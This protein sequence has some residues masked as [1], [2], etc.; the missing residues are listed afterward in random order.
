MAED[1]G[2]KVTKPGK[3]TSSTDPDDLV[4]SSE[5]EVRSIIPD[6]TGSSTLTT[7]TDGSWAD[8]EITHDLGY[9]PMVK[10]FTTTDQRSRY[11]ELPG[12]FRSYSADGECINDGGVP[13]Y[14]EEF[15]IE[16][17]DNTWIVSARYYLECVIP[18]WGT[19]YTYYE[20]TYT[21]DY[22][23]FREEVGL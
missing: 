11:V 23:T 12:R 2:V 6:K 1:Y 22:V 5:L 20:T 15:E 13:E 16:L 14:I 3:S 7:N 4:F 17:K 9:K 18:Q 10:A 19:D 21:I 8:L